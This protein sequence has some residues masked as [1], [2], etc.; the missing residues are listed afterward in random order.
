MMS[1]GSRPL[2]GRLDL[3]AV[4]A[5][6]GLDARRGRG[7]RT[8]RPRP[9]TCGARRR[10]PVERPAL[11][12][13]P[14][15]ALLGQAPAAVAGDA[16]EPDVVVRRARE[17]DEVRP[18][19]AR[20][21]DHEVDLRPAQD[22]DGRLRLARAQHLVRPRRGAVNRSTT[23]FGVRP[24]RRA[25]R[26]RRSSPA[27]GAA[28]PPGRCGVT[29]GTPRSCSARSSLAAWARWM[30]QPARARSRASRSPRGSRS[31]VLAEMPLSVRRRLFLRRLP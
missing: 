1:V 24:S 7:S 6:L 18:G 15:E 11:L 29:P 5:Q 10:R 26:G 9:R 23:V 31:S 25:G 13:D 22:R 12:V 17:V 4:L 14:Q 28:S 8:P 21:H 20:R 30:Q 27:G 3:A 2:A 16:A 19:L